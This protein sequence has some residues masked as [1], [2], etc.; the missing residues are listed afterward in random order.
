[1]KT[2]I[3]LSSNY[4]FLILLVAVLIVQLTSFFLLFDKANATSPKFI[5]QPGNILPNNLIKPTATPVEITRPL[6]P[7]IKVSMIGLGT[8]SI[9]IVLFG[10]W[11]NY[12][13][14]KK[15]LN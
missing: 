1:M 8:L 3:E 12:K 13:K 15:I 14:L 9:I 6:D 4:R 10:L 11:L 2:K 7:K 5:T